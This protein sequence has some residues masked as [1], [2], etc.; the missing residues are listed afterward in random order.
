M[1]GLG[2]GTHMAARDIEPKNTHPS[3]GL[4]VLA[5]LAVKFILETAAETDIQ[6]YS[7]GTEDL[8]RPCELGGLRWSVTAELGINGLW[9]TDVPLE[10]L[11]RG[12]LI[13]CEMA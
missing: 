9:V 2:A 1:R 10:M 7:G 5:D 4:L 3:L 13:R 11:A 8:S 6:A 12:Q